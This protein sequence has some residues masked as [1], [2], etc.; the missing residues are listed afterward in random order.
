MVNAKNTI[1]LT[2]VIVSFAVVALTGCFGGEKKTDQSPAK[3]EVQTQ[4]QQGTTAGT[5]TDIKSD[6]KTE[7]KEKKQNKD[8]GA[9]DSQQQAVEGPSCIID[10]Q[11]YSDIPAGASVGDILPIIASHIPNLEQY[12]E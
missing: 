4:V 5:K 1:F 12:K 2:I 10:G 11:S 9:D 6:K 3:T 8:K 7:E